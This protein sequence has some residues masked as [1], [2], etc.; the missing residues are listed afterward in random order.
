MVTY[1]KQTLDMNTWKGRVTL[2]LTLKTQRFCYK[3]HIFGELT[4]RNCLK[5]NK[6]E[7]VII[8]SKLKAISCMC[9]YEMTIMGLLS[10]FCFTPG[11]NSKHD[12]LYSPVVCRDSVVE[13][14][15]MNWVLFSLGQKQIWET[16]LQLRCCSG[17]RLVC[18]VLCI[19]SYCSS[20]GEI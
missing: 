20:I 11:W 12:Q 14:D 3:L 4:H 8:Y 6:L 13:E 17:R 9:P 19:L 15:L 18:S 16:W 7:I 10:W 2:C 5:W 1:L